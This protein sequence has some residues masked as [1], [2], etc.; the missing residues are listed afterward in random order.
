MQRELTVLVKFQISTRWT[1]RKRTIQV[2]IHDTPKELLAYANRYN[3]SI[4][5]DEVIT[6]AVGLCQSFTLEKLV[7]NE[8]VPTPAA[9]FLRF[10]TEALTS[11]IISH[12]AAH[13]ASNI[14]E[15]DWLPKHGPPWENIA[16]EEVLAYLVGDITSKVV[17]Q[18]YKRGLVD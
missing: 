16:N 1:E 12:E 10:S 8:W 7:N 5:S 14:Y 11:G 15:Q 13:M 2:Y 17:R 3:K 4:G 9:G 6:D 18:L